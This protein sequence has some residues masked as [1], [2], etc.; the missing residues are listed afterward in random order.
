MSI[1]KL[2]QCDET[3]CMKVNEVNERL[4][5]MMDTIEQVADED[6]KLQSMKDWNELSTS[7]RM[8]CRAYDEG[9]CEFGKTDA[10]NMFI[11]GFSGV[12]IGNLLRKIF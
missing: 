10:I 2:T 8:M 9:I 1:K 3:I 12:L 6:V 5:N 11:T 4:K 7:T